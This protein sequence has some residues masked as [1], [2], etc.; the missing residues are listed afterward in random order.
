MAV[1]DLDG[2]GDP[3]IVGAH[4]A[5][6]VTYLND[7]DGGFLQA[8]TQDFPGLYNI[9]VGDLD[10]DGTNDLVATNQGYALEDV[11]LLLNDGTGL[12]Q[13]VSRLSTGT[14]VVALAVGDL[15]ANAFL[16]VVAISRYEKITVFMDP[17][18]P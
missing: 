16:D 13:E 17:L 9:A 11:C 5:G 2:D 3:D 6:I 12:F 1:A 15:D 8:A 14:S 18:A 7:G 10:G 4:A